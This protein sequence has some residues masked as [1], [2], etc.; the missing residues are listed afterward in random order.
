LSDEELLARLGA[1][2][3]KFYWL[4]RDFDKKVH[5]GSVTEYV[6]SILRMANYNGRTMNQH[7]FE[8]ICHILKGAFPDRTGLHFPRPT[9]G[10]GP[11]TEKSLASS[12]NPKFV[13]KCLKLRNLLYFT[14]I[15]R[16]YGIE[17]TG[18]TAGAFV[19]QYVDDINEHGKSNVKTSWNSVVG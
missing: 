2:S 7:S 5:P 12:S 4:L 19:K 10:S 3:P 6:E 18:T 8:R 13:S 11:I 16:L 1:N 15:K 14:P 17:L 9:L